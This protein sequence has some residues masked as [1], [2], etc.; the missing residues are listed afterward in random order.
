LPLLYLSGYGLGWLFWLIPNKKRR[1]TYINLS[2]CLPELTRWQRHNLARRSLIHEAQTLLEIPALLHLP[3][4]RLQSL[5][6]EVIGLEYLEQGMEKGKGVILAIPHLGNWEMIGLYASALYPMTSLYR[7]QH[8]SPQ[9]DDFIRTGRQRFN[10]RLVP[11]D[12]GGV[13][14]LYKALE[15]NELIAILP[16]QNPGRGSGVFAPFFGHTAN[17]MVLL[18]R[19]AQRNHATVL[20]SYT[21]RLRWG[22]GFRIHFV[23][24]SDD[25]YNPDRHL[26]ASAINLGLEHCIRQAPTQY[27]WSYK[28]FNVQPDGE[29]SPYS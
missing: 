16:D 6:H 8:R 12:A 4:Q 19:L 2:I 24:A 21:E 13:R 22:R 15:H 25:I 5:A 11:T 20:Y 17:T 18:S 27:W 28:R 9:L 10:A 14:A 29:N 23:P 26:S 1:I 7:P 3:R